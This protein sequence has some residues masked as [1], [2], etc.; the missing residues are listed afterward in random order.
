MA[1]SLV[2]AIGTHIVTTAVCMDEETGTL[3]STRLLF[4]GQA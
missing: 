1:G 4:K 3:T 2:E